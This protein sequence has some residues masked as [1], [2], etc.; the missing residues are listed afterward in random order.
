M[1]Q[2]RVRPLAW[3]WNF[4]NWDGNMPLEHF[5]RTTAAWVVFFMSGAL[6]QC[7]YTQKQPTPQQ[8]AGI[9]KDAAR[10]FGDDP[11]NG[12]PIATDLSYS[13]KPDAVAKAMR[14]VADWQMERARPYFD[15]IW[16]WSVLYSG[17]MAASES[18]G[19]A[20]YR[21][22]MQAVGQKFEWKLRS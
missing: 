17:F 7:A 15:R 22:A 6:T 20:K 21:D 3:N 4:E 8:L 1:R 5:T 13:V 12:G 9:A 14:K 2:V 19:D 10:H 18:L 11:D 16:T